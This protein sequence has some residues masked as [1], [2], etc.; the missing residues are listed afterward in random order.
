[1]ER[2]DALTSGRPRGTIRQRLVWGNVAINLL[3]LLIAGICLWQISRLVRAVDVLQAA[4][5]RA[6]TALEVHR[7]STELLA[8][9]NRLV[10]VEDAEVFRTEVAAALEELQRSHADLVT[11]TSRAISDE[12]AYPL[13]NRVSSRIDSV[14][15]VVETMVRQARAGQWP[16]VRVRLA[17][18]QRDHQHLGLE[19]N[20]LLEL[21]IEMEKEAAR[22]VKLARRAA[23]FYAALA[24]VFGITL[25]VLLTLR[26]VRSIVQPVE[27]LTQGADQWAA[28]F[29][30][31]RVAV[32]GADEFGQLAATFNQMAER[33]QTSHT[34]LERRVV[35]RTADLQQ[36][37]RELARE[38]N[39]LEATLGA[40]PDLLFEVDR[41]GRIFDYRVP[42]PELLHIPPEEFLQGQTVA[43]MLPE[44]VARIILVALD[45]AARTGHH[46]GTTYSLETGRGLGWFELS[47]AAKGDPDDPE[48]RFVALV[49][50]V[51]AR[52]EAGAALR[53]SEERYRTILEN[54]EDG[55]YE[56]DL[57]GHFTFFNSSLCDMMGY[58][59][60]EM[61]GM[62]YKQYMDEQTAKSVYRTFNTV[63]RTGQPTRAV[64]WEIIRK[65]GGLRFIEASVTLM[66]DAAGEPVGFRG[67]VRDVSE[68][69][70]AEAAMLQH[71]AELQARNE[72]LDAFA[73]TV[74][75]DLKNPL[76]LVVGHAEVLQEYA[77][78]L[79]PDLQ[80]SVSIIAQSGRKMG[81]IIDALL[82]LS[83]VRKVAD[84][85]LERLDMG[86]LV[87]EALDRL[88]YLIEAYQAEVTLPPAEAWPEALG[89][90]PW[91]EEVWVNY[92]SNAIQ[93]G[94]RPPRL[95]LGA[96]ETENREVSFWVRDN[97][98][99]LTPKEQARLFTPF[100]RLDQVRAKGHG[101]GL[102]IVRRIVEKLGGQ[103]AVESEVGQGSRFSFSL[104]T[105]GKT[106]QG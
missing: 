70:R 90:A 61:M 21:A 99:G 27:R 38:R 20:E 49:R 43:E 32:E 81:D 35:E 41:Q 67:I 80:K 77:G 10:P 44:Q 29:L 30:D 56:V 94:G 2:N 33:L 6:T 87:A 22:Q 106:R 24:V 8:I 19:T 3:L 91:V 28:G 79:A 96:T 26:T 66:R 98:P 40:L 82:L 9:V 45:Q 88:A 17:V 12:E 51:T 31:K 7:N 59:D 47:V 58:S 34:E 52:V 5:Q 84:I 18:L 25:S 73:H 50:D 64:D 62:H 103:V 75:H 100:T 4:R 76:A 57:A 39:M 69:K 23:F 63:Y 89:Y 36:A 15:G 78:S 86:A 14:I 48:A 72:E 105:A 60:D 97:G 71:A 65:D 55:Y 37:M 13:M 101:L 46:A 16:S 92:L 11:L 54:I 83:S 53:E 68:R 74:A 93:Y 1:M 42:H 95:T 104:P 102:S 85:E